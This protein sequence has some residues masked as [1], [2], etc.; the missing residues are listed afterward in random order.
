[1]QPLKCLKTLPKS[2][3][4]L[5]LDYQAFEFLAMLLA[6]GLVAVMTLL[7]STGSGFSLGGFAGGWLIG[8]GFGRWRFGRKAQV[9]ERE[10]ERTFYFSDATIGPRTD[11]AFYELKP[12][13][14]T[15]A[16]VNA[17]D[18]LV[19]T[20]LETALPP[21]VRRR[22]GN[23]AKPGGSVRKRAKAVPLISTPQT[24]SKN[25][26]PTHPKEK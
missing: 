8:G 4:R 17:P 10:Q 19:K 3:S 16:E 25:P 9:E 11:L 13:K 18:K 20:T 6:S 12:G 7:V 21:G 2:P 15:L 14:R 26:S 5:G 1:N 22:V 24:Q 23:E